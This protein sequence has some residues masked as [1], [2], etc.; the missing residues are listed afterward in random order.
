MHKTFLL[1]DHVGHLEGLA[2]RDKAYISAV[3]T[4]QKEFSMK[5][6]GVLC[7]GDLL[8]FPSPFCEAVLDELHKGLL[9]VEKMCCWPE[10]GQDIPTAAKNCERCLHKGHS[11]PDH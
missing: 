2:T 9:G 10:L 8:T 11:Q 4:H 1:P 5:P 7:L 6:D 3:F